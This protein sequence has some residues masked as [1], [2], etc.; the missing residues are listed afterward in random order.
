MTTLLPPLSLPDLTHPLTGKCVSGSTC[1]GVDVNVCLCVGILRGRGICGWMGG[2]YMHVCIWGA[3]VRDAS[4]CA[5]VCV[6]ED[7]CCFGTMCVDLN[8]I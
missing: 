8:A 3:G 2:E 4:V 6:R 5:C 7:A 1:V